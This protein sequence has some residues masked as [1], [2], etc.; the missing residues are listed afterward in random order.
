MRSNKR[1][2]AVLMT[3]SLMVL[4]ISAKAQT[5]CINAR[6]NGANIESAVLEFMSVDGRSVERRDLVLKAI[7]P[8]RSTI[9]VG[10][11]D[12]DVELNYQTWTEL[13]LIVHEFSP[14]AQRRIPEKSDLPP[15]DH[16]MVPIERIEVVRGIIRF[17]GCVVPLEEASGEVRFNGTLTFDHGRGLVDINGT[18]SRYEL[19][20]EK[21]GNPGRSK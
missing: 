12:G 8:D 10:D 15:M 5:Y 17:P 3:L 1:S 7:R 18:V 13:R 4:G 14:V 6:P 11:G 21:D 19:S 9:V 16:V 20:P 2:N